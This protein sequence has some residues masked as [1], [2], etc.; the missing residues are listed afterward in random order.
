MFKNDKIIYDK[1][2]GGIC[3]RNFFISV[4]ICAVFLYYIPINKNK[5]E[6]TEAKIWTLTFF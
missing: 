1:I 4:D 3:G 5:S 6:F 2:T